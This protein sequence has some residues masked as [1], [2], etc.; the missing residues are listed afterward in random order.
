MKNYSI[1][2]LIAASALTLAACDKYLDVVPDSRAVLDSEEKITSLLVSAYPTHSLYLHEEFASD[3]TM[4][5]GSNFTV[6][7]KDHEEAYLW[8]PV[9]TQTNDCTKSIWN[10]GFSCIAAANQA[11][12]A[13]KDLGNPASLDAQKGEALLCRAYSYFRLANLYC[14][15]YDPETADKCFGLPYNTEPETSVKPEYHRGTLKSLYEHISADIEEALPLVDDNIYTV[16]KYH[17]NK[18]AAY[19]FAA[20]FNLYYHNMDKVIEYATVALG[21]NPQKSMKDYASISTAASNFE[22]RCN[23]YLSASDP[24]NFMLHTAYSSFA[25][26]WGP[27]SLGKRYGNSKELFT[28]EGPRAATGPWGSYSY[29]YFSK[30]AWGFEQKLALPKNYGY[31]EYTDKTAGIGYRQNVNLAFSGDETILC[32]A[33]AYA[34]KGE[35]DLAVNDINTWIYTHTSN[36]KTFTKAQLVEH[37]TKIKCMPLHVTKASDR[38]IKKEINPV[39]FTIAEGDQKEIIQCILHLRR[40]ETVGEGLRWEDIKR[41]GIEFA[42]NREG[43]DDDVLTLDDPRRAFQIPV[44][45]IDAGLEPNP[46]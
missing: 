32:R 22:L 29:L 38:T 1:I 40:I 36:K 9:N 25:Y 17:F 18:K 45:V 35:L 14:L 8:E 37:Y 13:I 20:R 46:R 24:G 31:F 21:S 16:P 43:M 27:Y 5:N 4:D 15:A 34:R 12:A 6:S 23:M 2:A 11:I 3:N 28:N 7:T 42:H 41:Y 19:A 10:D 44:D 30:S 26:Y 39:G 33:E